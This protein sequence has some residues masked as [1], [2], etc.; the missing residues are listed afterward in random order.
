M[1]DRDDLFAVHGTSSQSASALAALNAAAFSRMRTITTACFGDGQR[2][3]RAIRSAT[4]FVSQDVRKNR[5]RLS[6]CASA[7]RSRQSG[8]SFGASGAGS[9]GR[10]RCASGL[11]VRLAAPADQLRALCAPLVR[12][13]VGRNS[14]LPRRSRRRAAIRG[15]ALCSCRPCVAAWLR[16]LSRSPSNAEPSMP[17]SLSRRLRS[18]FESWRAATVEASDERNFVVEDVGHVR[19][20]GLRLLSAPFF[21]FSVVVFSGLPLTLP[22]ATPPS[23]LRR[24]N[25]RRPLCL[26]SGHLCWV[27]RWSTLS[28]SPAPRRSRR[29]AGPT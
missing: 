18:V 4:K 10:V 2:V 15:S 11:L 19:L 27:G 16:A 7:K 13:A 3:P 23:R 14:I 12:P 28:A 5:E 6:C 29:D 22:W 26:P 25:R 1:T 17:T 8:G 24:R 9:A 21:D 20:F